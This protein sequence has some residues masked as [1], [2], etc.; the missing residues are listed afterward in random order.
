MGLALALIFWVVPPF[1]L[2]ISFNMFFLACK[3]K[4]VAAPP[5]AFILLIG[6]PPRQAGGRSVYGT[7]YTYSTYQFFCGSGLSS[8][9]PALSRVLAF[10]R[11]FFRRVLVH[12]YCTFSTQLSHVWYT[13]IARSVHKNRTPC[14]GCIS[15]PITLL[16]SLAIV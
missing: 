6:Q 10:L 15:M 11:L 1:R 14:Y 9:K 13:I 8:K 3:E 7:Y 5:A 2:R 4:P 16:P 12:N